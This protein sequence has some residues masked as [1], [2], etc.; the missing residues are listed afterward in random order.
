MNQ[1][2]PVLDSFCN[3]IQHDGH[4]V[5]N[6]VIDKPH[7]TNAVLLDIS[8]SSGVTFFSPT[9]EM[10]ISVQFNSQFDCRA[11]KIDNIGPNTVLSPPFKL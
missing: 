3:G 5:M 10:A 1:Y 11:I 6:V 9:S 4:V 8:L 2:T 7:Y